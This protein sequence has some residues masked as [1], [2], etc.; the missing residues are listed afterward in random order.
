MRRLQLI[1]AAC[2]VLSAC[3]ARPD[4]G[5]GPDAARGPTLTEWESLHSAA[6]FPLIVSLPA[7]PFGEPWEFYSFAHRRIEGSGR[8]QMAWVVDR[9]VSRRGGMP[10]RTAVNSRSC[11]AILALLDEA[12]TLAAPQVRVADLEWRE[13]IGIPEPRGPAPDQGASAT[14][15]WNLGDSAR[16]GY[17]L[18][19]GAA[20]GFAQRVRRAVKACADKPVSSANP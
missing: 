5:A 11:P 7:G 18:F 3:A 9:S 20:D 17:S 6:A 15:T 1:G 13:P 16:H 4:A 2:V 10:A 19:G 14:V 8:A 12:T